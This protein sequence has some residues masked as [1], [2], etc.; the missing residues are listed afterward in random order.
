MATR[1]YA[2]TDGNYNEVTN[3]TITG[4]LL[5]ENSIGA[6]DRDLSIGNGPEGHDYRMGPDEATYNTIAF[7]GSAI[8]NPLPSG[9]SPSGVSN[10][11]FFGALK[12][13]NPDENFTILANYVA[14]LNLNG[15]LTGGY[16]DAV[17]AQNAINSPGTG[18]FTN[19]AFD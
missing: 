12:S 17:A 7:A 8:A 18:F 6:S 2:Y 3:F 14:G 5:Y 1:A 16:A 13:G 4:D 10:L 11:T 19:A 15:N 9:S